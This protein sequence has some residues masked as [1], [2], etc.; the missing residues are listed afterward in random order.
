MEHK[1]NGEKWRKKTRKK[2]EIFKGAG[3]L[4]LQDGGN[5][6]ERLWE[7]MMRRYKKEGIK[8][9]VDLAQNRNTTGQVEGDRVQNRNSKENEW[10][11]V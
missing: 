2:D 11:N 1:K 7:K 6:W 4:E 8:K 5:G 10:K 3:R 9:W